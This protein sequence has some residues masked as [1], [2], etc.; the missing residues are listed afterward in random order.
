M[1]CCDVCFPPRPPQP[2]SYKVGSQ[3]DYGDDGEDSRVGI[4][5][6]KQSSELKFYCVNTILT[7]SKLLL[8]VSTSIAFL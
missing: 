6:T 8:E 7:N 4:V 5:K 3:G 1:F 2:Y